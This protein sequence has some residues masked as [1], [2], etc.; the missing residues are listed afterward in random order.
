MPDF[1]GLPANN[2]PALTDLIA[3]QDPA[4]G[5]SSTAK[6]TLAEAFAHVVLVNGT[7]ELTADWDAGAFEIAAESFAADNFVLVGA[8]E[9]TGT[10]SKVSAYG[11]N[12]GKPTPATNTACFYAKDVGGVVTPCVVNEVG[13]EII[14]GATLVAYDVEVNGSTGLV[15]KKGVGGTAQFILAA[16]GAVPNVDSFDFQMDPNYVYVWN[17]RATPIAFGINS[18]ARVIFSTAGIA[19]GTLTFPTGTIGGVLT[20]CDNTG[21]PT[22]GAN[23]AGVFAKDVSGTVEVFVIDEGGTATQISE[24]AS[25]AP[26]WLYDHA[27]GMRERVARE[28]DNGKIRWT[29]RTRME[30]LLE[31]LLTGEPIPTSPDK[32]KFTHIET[33]DEY[34]RRIS[35]GQSNG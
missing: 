19:I 20:L 5:A 12:A 24:H 6:S 21:N 27:D 34:E 14:L 31:S 29:N 13:E 26:E 33:T 16:D 30:R 9:P 10:A 11:D 22:M 7:Q 32:L 17:R 15:I 18:T 2:T 25:D 8:A 4:G 1:V 23:T 35:T 3:V 28:E